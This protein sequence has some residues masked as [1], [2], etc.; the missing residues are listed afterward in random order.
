MKHEL[1]LL[2]LYCALPI[3]RRSA[4]TLK[5]AP[6]EILEMRAC[7]P[8]VP[9]ALRA[10]R[11][12]RQSL[13]AAERCEPGQTEINQ[14]L[15]VPSHQ[16]MAGK[17]AI[18]AHQIRTFGQRLRIALTICAVSSAGP[19]YTFPGSVPPNTPIIS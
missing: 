8:L 5:R 13:T 11:S 10:A 3:T 19:A 17:A 18:G 1:A 9:D 15:F 12:H 7:S 6:A 4:P 16:L 14:T 2:P